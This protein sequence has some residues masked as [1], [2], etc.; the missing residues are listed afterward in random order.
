VL[1]HGLGLSGAL[2]NRMRDGFGSGYRLITLDLR[3]AGRSRELEPTELS[4]AGWADDLHAVVRELELDRPVLVGASLGAA[5]ALQYALANPGEAGAWVWSGP[6][7][8]LPTPAP[9]MRAAAGRTDRA[10]G[11]R[12]VGGGGWETPPFSPASLRRD[13]SILDE[14]RTWL[15]ANDAADYVR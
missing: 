5:V 14:Y 15:L 4:L 8:H 2:W 10:A 11:R 9:R 12:G 3:G 6:G 7:A 1:V 13:P